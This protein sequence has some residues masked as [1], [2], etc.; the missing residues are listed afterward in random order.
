[1]YFATKR[2]IFCVFS[3]WKMKKIK[4][5]HER[6]GIGLSDKELNKEFIGE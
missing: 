1:M 4:E 3:Q 5:K 2:W 6:Y